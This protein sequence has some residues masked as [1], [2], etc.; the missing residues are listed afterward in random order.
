MYCTSKMQKMLDFFPSFQF[1]SF[2]LSAKTKAN[3]LELIIEPFN[4]HRGIC[5]PKRDYFYNVKAGNS[6]DNK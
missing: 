4:S 1:T 2:H 5:I 6:I 3:L